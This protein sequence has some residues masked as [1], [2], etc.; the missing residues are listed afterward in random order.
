MGQATESNAP[1]KVQR[2]KAAYVNLDAYLYHCLIG[3][4]YFYV[5]LRHGTFV[6]TFLLLPYC[7]LRYVFT[8]S[9]F[10]FLLLPYVMLCYVFTFYACTN[11]LQPSTTT[12][13]QVTKDCSRLYYAGLSGTCA[14]IGTAENGQRRPMVHHLQ[15]ISHCAFRG[16]TPIDI[17][18]SLWPYSTENLTLRHFVG[19]DDWHLPSER[20]HTIHNPVDWRGSERVIRCTILSH[21]ESV[22]PHRHLK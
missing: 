8:F 4:F 17:S 18:G 20:G 22:Q 14:P 19:S 9:V 5:K 2:R 1:R 15:E 21:P 16:V 13:T 11:Q 3:G 12:I 7:A 10:T 6:F